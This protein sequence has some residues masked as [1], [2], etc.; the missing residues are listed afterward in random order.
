MQG[1]RICCL[2]FFGCLAFSCN[3]NTPEKNN[4]PSHL[5][6]ATELKKMADQFPDSLQLIEQ[7]IQYYRDEGIY[8]SAIMVT[9][10]AIKRDSQV[11]R[12]WDIKATL[13]YE[14]RDTLNSIRSFEKAISIYPLPEYVISLGTLYAQTKNP[15]AIALADAL[16]VADK[17]KAEKE[18]IFIKGLYYNYIGNKNKAIVLFDSCIRKDYTYMFA[19]REKAIALY[20]MGKY[21]D[22]VEVLNKAITVQNNFEEGYYWLGL[23]FEK[24]NRIQDAIQSY[25]TALMYDKDYVEARDALKR[26]GV[27]K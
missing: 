2:V 3:N 24:L 26:L 14:N 8:D 9:D 23:C 5:N 7:L 18:A 12:L 6:S 27:N 13:H 1:Y 10:L 19:Y 21:N 11:A 4:E 16:I 20:D 15:K 25:H 22:A 17:S